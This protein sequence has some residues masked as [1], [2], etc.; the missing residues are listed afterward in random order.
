[1]RTLRSLGVY[2]VARRMVA[3]RTGAMPEARAK[4]E[5]I[6]GRA[7][8]SFPF[9]S[10]VNAKVGYIDERR[11]IRMAPQ[12]TD[13]GA[14]SPSHRSIISHIAFLFSSM[15]AGCNFTALREI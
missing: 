12:L 1:M 3:L 8:P 7:A 5:T 2:T 11:K 14:S 4:R 13:C 10:A 15:S 9:R 6:T